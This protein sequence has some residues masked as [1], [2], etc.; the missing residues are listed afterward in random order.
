M[1]LIRDL[2][3]WAG[4]RQVAGGQVV[5]HELNVTVTAE[6]LVVGLHWHKCGVTTY[7]V[8]QHGTL[9][10]Q[11]SAA[12]GC[13]E[14]VRSGAAGAGLSAVRSRRP[15]RASAHPSCIRQVPRVGSL[16][17]PQRSDVNTTANCD[18]LLHAASPRVEWP[19]WCSW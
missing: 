14:D 18:S 8:V 11:A 7:S 5:H 2:V 1:P 4:F 15:G 12:A 13:E 17:R 3:S 6:R 10:I 9:T 16:Y 19:G